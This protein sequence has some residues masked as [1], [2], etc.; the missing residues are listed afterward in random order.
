M[1]MCGSVVTRTVCLPTVGWPQAADVTCLC[2]DGC[3]F[4]LSVYRVSWAPKE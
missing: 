2:P 3:P 4:V 1:K